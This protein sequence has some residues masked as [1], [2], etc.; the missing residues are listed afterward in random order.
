M[1]PRGKAKMKP[2]L[3]CRLVIALLLI[4]IVVSGCGM[5]D[6]LATKGV[7]DLSAW[8][9][10][11]DG[12]VA[13]DGQWAFHWGALLTPAQFRAAQ[14]PPVTGYFT[15]PAYWNGYRVNGV[16]L[17]G[18]GYATFRLIVR[19][20]PREKDLAL[21]IE[22]QSTAYRLWV[23]GVP[24]MGNGIVAETAD[25][26]QPYRKISTA[27]VP[28]GATELDCVLQVSNFHLANGG[29]YRR[30]ILGTRDAID[31]RQNRLFA[32]DLLLCGVLGFI[33]IYHLVFHLLRNK[34]PSLLYFGFFCLC[35]SI[36]IPFGGLGG[37]FI[38]LICPDVPWYWMARME[39]LTWFP[40]VPLFLMFFASLYPQEF[41]VKATRFAQIVAVVF[42]TFVLFAPSRATGLT[43]VP[44]Q[45]FSM[46]VIIYICLRLYHAVRCGRGEARLMLAGF[47][48]F[49]ATVV[50]D[51]LY[52]NLI[53]YSVYLTSA[54]IGV[55]ILF[56]TFALA[57]RFAQSF[58][59]VEILTGELEQKN[60]ALSRLDKLKDQFLANTSHELRTPLNGII[61]IA[62]SLIGGVTGTLPEKTR[63]NLSLIVASGRRLTNLINDVL[64]LA[65]L[66]HKD[67]HLHIKPVDI[68]AVTDT[69][70]RVMKPLADAK[71]LVLHNEIPHDMP[72]AMADEERLQQIL[73]NLVGNALKFTDLGSVRISARQR[74]A[75]IEVAVADTGIGIPEDKQSLIFQSFEQIDATDERAY[76][77]AGLGLSITRQLVALH[78]G[79]IDVA[80]TPGEGTVFRFS[81][82][83]VPPDGPAAG[84]PRIPVPVAAPVTPQVPVAVD[85][86]TSG[87]PGFDARAT[88][89]AVDDD[90]I[91]LQVVANYLAYSNVT[92]LTAAGGRQAIAGIA[93]GPLPDIILLDIMMPRM[94]GYEVCRWLRQRYTASELP[95]IFLTAKSGPG[96]PA[97]GFAEGANDYLAKPF[98]KE[99]LVARVVSQ[100]KLKRAYLTLRENL[101]LRRELAARQATERELRA[102]QRWLSAMLD[103]IDDALM[104]VNE[105]GEITFCNRI[106]E[107][108]LGC[109]VEALLGRPFN[110]MARRP[111]GETLSADGNDFLLRCFDGRTGQPIGR[112]HLVRRDG[113]PCPADI[114]PSR[115]D[116]DGEPVCLLII[117]KAGDRQAGKNIPQSLAVVEAINQ[118]RVRLQSIQ[119]TLNGLRP[120]IDHHQPEFLKELKAID[121]ALDSVGRTVFQGENH[122]SR[123]H[124]GAEVM[125]CALDYWIQCTGLSKADLAR[126]SK[127][128]KTYT[129]QDGWERTQTLDRYLNIEFFPQRPAWIKIFKTAQFV[130]VN[131]TVD[132]PLRSRLEVLLT[133]LRVRN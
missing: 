103:S 66:R 115:L 132:S 23:N 2:I 83:L 67:L 57:K 43:E 113:A 51:I 39:L 100:L 97:H 29:P 79:A 13:L 123:R 111:S 98:V 122:A 42:F 78:G 40:I 126:Q 125:T 128:W 21:R 26:M 20:K 45:I 30:I 70:L 131:G 61:G 129:N 32:L 80:S 120:L 41:S 91:N 68:R 116:V 44:Y 48:F 106:C 90:P 108:L 93:S 19:L 87:L 109:G 110:E 1:R 118:N 54:G 119:T 76:G 52:M 31:Q 14:I 81:L 35:W 102:V 18:D 27:V 49:M 86:P 82:P 65:R 36:G 37:R 64:D 117:R 58:A 56:Q 17:A 77:G 73:Y 72:P 53:I 46:G 88:L 85:A 75:R 74:D 16:P 10:E 89:L 6:P 11:R 104:A 25:A 59:A 28:A 5:T 62:E 94:N 127:L 15:S 7:L 84:R 60:V 47:F 69:V 38:T 114:Y 63:R 101:S 92:V 96:D 99:E 24:V 55:M 133:K 71:S 112:V 22:D 12:I 105:S 8:D 124:L 4:T 34:E 121:Q 107:A 3:V 33:G 50:N 95:V 9:F 130:L